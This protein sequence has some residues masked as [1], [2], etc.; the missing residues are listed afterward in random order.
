MKRGFEG[1]IYQGTAGTTAS[2]LI[3]NRVDVSY[4]IDPQMTPSHV[5]GAG[6][7]PPKEAEVVTSVKFSLSLK[8]RNVAGDAVLTALRT[9][10]AAGT[11]V[12]IRMIDATAGKGYDGDM[13]VKESWSGPLGGGQDFDFTF[14]TNNSLRTPQYY[15]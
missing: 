5:A 9:A 2:T 1:L 15:V 10:A 14:T 7:S 4:D 8:M 13:N 3:S 6:T 11:P 12:A